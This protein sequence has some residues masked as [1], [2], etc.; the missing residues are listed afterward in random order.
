MTTIHV[1]VNDK[2]RGFLGKAAHRMI[3]GVAKTTVVSPPSFLLLLVFISPAAFAQTNDNPVT[4]T[5]L[6]LG[7]LSILSH[8]V[9]FSSPDTA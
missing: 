2:A 7:D 9:F 1:L 3:A 4:S 8:A 6:S 5:S